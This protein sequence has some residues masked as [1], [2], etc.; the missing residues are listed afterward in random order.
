MTRPAYGNESELIS[1]MGD[2]GSATPIQRRL[3]LIS[4]RPDGGTAKAR[5]ELARARVSA[6]HGFIRYFCVRVK[7]KVDYDCPSGFFR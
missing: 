1:K 3:T 2:R 4:S 6:G 7:T 5:C